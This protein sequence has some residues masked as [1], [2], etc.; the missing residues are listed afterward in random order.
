MKSTQQNHSHV[1]V[2]EARS[3]SIRATSTGRRTSSWSEPWLSESST[4]LAHTAVNEYKNYCHYY[5]MCNSESEMGKS[6]TEIPS[7]LILWKAASRNWILLNIQKGFPWNL[8][9]P[10][11][12]ARPFPASFIFTGSIFQIFD[13]MSSF[14]DRKVIRGEKNVNLTKTP[15]PVQLFPFYC[16]TH[17]SCLFTGWEERD[18]G[19]AMSSFRRQPNE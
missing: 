16:S 12:H 5:L 18:L 10:F 6:E 7:S 15:F 2:Y 13:N 8:I 1:D 3:S 17:L 14:C 9:F 4:I 19:T 11:L